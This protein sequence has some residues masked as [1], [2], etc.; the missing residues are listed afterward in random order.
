MTYFYILFEW[1]GI[2]SG[3]HVP[4]AEVLYNLKLSSKFQKKN[5]VLVDE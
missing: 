2:T 3:I 5:G 4:Q 1:L